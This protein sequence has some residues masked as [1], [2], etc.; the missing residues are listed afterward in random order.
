MPNIVFNFAKGVVLCEL[1]NSFCPGSVGKIHKPRI[2]SV[3][4][5]MATDNINQFFRACEKIKFPS[6]YMFSVPGKI[7]ELFQ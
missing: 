4:E 5:F 6:I 7:I 2:G 1:A 3:L